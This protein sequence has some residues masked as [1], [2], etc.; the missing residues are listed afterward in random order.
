MPGGES[1]AL[2]LTVDADDHGSEYRAVFTNAAGAIATTAARITVNTAPTVLVQPSDVTAVAGQ[3]ALFKVMPG[4]NPEPRSSGSAASTA[5]GRTSTPTAA[6]SP[7][8]AA[9]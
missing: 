9:S 4:G 6:T 5:S 7:S 8:T 2:E 1:T 3:P